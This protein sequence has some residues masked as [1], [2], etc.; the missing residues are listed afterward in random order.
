MK[1]TI[2]DSEARVAVLT[3]WIPTLKKVNGLYEKTSVQELH[4]LHGSWSFVVAQLKGRT[5]HAVK[6]RW[7][8]FR[9][10]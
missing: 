8:S 9:Q 2:V 10:H 1:A 4:K 3:T 5:E 6:N 7:H